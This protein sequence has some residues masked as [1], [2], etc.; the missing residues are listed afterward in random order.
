MTINDCESSAYSHSRGFF[1]DADL[2]NRGIRPSCAAQRVLA[3]LTERQCVYSAG[4][5]N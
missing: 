2:G 4:E 5:W 1:F 3:P